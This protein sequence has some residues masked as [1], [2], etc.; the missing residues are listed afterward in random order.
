MSSQNVTHPYPGGDPDYEW[1]SDTIADVADVLN[2][3]GF[4]PEGEF[5]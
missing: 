5:D 4:V 2:N 3:F 1:S